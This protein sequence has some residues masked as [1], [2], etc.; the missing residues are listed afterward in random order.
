[1]NREPGSIHVVRIIG[2]DIE[3]NRADR[4]RRA[5]SDKCPKL[6]ECK[7]EYARTVLVFESDDIALTNHHLVAE[8]LASVLPERTDIPD[9]IYLVESDTNTWYTWLFKHDEDCWAMQGL[10]EQ[11]PVI[12]Q[13]DEL[14]DLT[15]GCNLENP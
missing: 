8:A 9:E 4:L 7:A 15:S 6:L 5:L 2:D 3:S 12:F 13:E 14:I 10:D 11:K 1:M